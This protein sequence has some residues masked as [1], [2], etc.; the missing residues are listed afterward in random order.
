M[1]EA[2]V[3]AMRTKYILF[4]LIKFLLIILYNLVFVKQVDFC[5]QDIAAKKLTSNRSMKKWPCIK[6]S[7]IFTLFKE[8]KKG[9]LTLLIIT[10]HP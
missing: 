7:L 1:N 8:M 4:I 3:F 5:P 10:S 9:T 2:P 6:S